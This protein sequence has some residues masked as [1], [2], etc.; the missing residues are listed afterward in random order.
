MYVR[1]NLR[2]YWTDFAEIFYTVCNLVQLKI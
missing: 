1:D 2:N